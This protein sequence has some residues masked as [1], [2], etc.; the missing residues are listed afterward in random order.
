MLQ[1]WNP[2]IGPDCSNLEFM[3]GKY[4][5]VGPPGQTGKFT[6][7][8]PST[9]P[10]PSI[11]TPPDTFTWGPA[12]DTFTSSINFTTVWPF[13][14]DDALVPTNTPSLPSADDVSA[15]LERLEFCPF[16]DELNSTIWDKGLGDE[17]YH[18]HSWDL[19]FDCMDEY[20]DPYCFPRPD[21]PVLPSPTDIP[22]SCYP[23]ITTIVP[24]GWVE[25]P[26]P[27]ETGAP[28]NCNKWHLVQSGDSCA[29]IAANYGITVA[30]LHDYN[31]SINT[32][33]TDLR[34]SFAICVRVWDEP[35]VTTTSSPGPPGPT[36]SGTSPTCTKWHI[37]AE[38][39]S[40]I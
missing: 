24:H 12:P 9:T 29:G 35:P 28:D 26:G 14:T 18:L 6:P 27:T 31:P 23:T 8:V 15:I 22:S 2:T 36:A 3:I 4:I 21:D 39:M 5:C 1:S 10:P 17:E 32:Q 34:A 25:P 37:L 40:Y 38:G 19:E 33:C 11:T 16:N 30:Q 20:W 7:V 13:P